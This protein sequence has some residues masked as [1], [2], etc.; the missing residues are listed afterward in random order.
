MKSLRALLVA[1]SALLLVA[2]TPVLPT[3]AMATP[4]GHGSAHE[5]LKPPDLGQVLTVTVD[6]GSVVLTGQSSVIPDAPAP[7]EAEPVGAGSDLAPGLLLHID[8]CTTVVTRLLHDGANP[9]VQ[10]P[11]SGFRGAPTVAGFGGGSSLR[12]VR[13]TTSLTEST[14]A[15]PAAAAADS[16]SVQSSTTA[17]Q[18]EAV[19]EQ[20]EIPVLIVHGTFSNA[21]EVEPLKENLESRGL[22]VYSYTYG[23]A[24]SLIG[25]LDPAAGGIQN[26]NLSVEDLAAQIARAKAETGS[27]QIDLVGHSQ[28]GLL[29]KDYL[30]HYSDDGVRKVVDLAA[31]NHGTTFGG[32]AETLLNAFAPGLVDPLNAVFGKKTVQYFLSGNMLFDVV[33]LFPGP[34]Q[35]VVRWLADR[36]VDA[37]LGVAPRQQLLGSSFIDAL[38]QTPDTKPGVN[39]L[40]IATRDDDWVTPYRSTYL[41][42]VI[43]AEVRNVEVHSLPGVRPDEVILHDDLLT[44]RPVADAVADFLTSPSPAPDPDIGITTTID[45]GTTTIE[46]VIRTAADSA[47]ANSVP[48]SANAD[49]QIN[50]AEL[51]PSADTRLPARTAAATIRQTTPASTPPT[52]ANVVDAVAD[53]A[54]PDVGGPAPTRGGGS[55]KRPLSHH[56]Q[57]RQAHIDRRTLAR[58]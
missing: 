37:V 23:R 5:M 43:G 11:S 46:Q 51:Q 22:T 3:H 55:L 9:R 44:N 20:T 41:K 48:R 10:A 14:N 4:L 21:T 52:P 2:S 29:I 27:D 47:E 56:R 31:T 15:V 8:A 57:G 7:R 38:D 19:A 28:G 39:Y 13:A 25:L 40:V 33:A 6:Y 1:A 53:N 42:A 58:T 17:A 24:F 50:L 32:G 16:V 49:T 34:L 18:P 54:D 45:G 30:A 35:P 26:M 12:G 36:V